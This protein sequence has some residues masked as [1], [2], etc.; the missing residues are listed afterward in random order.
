MLTSALV[1]MQ[2]LLSGASGA[3][4]MPSTGDPAPHPLG[5]TRQGDSLESGQFAGKV[6]VVSFW[7]SW[8]GPCM[9]ELPRLEAIQRVAGKDKLQVVA[10]NMEE[11]ERFR[12][13]SKAL[14]SYSLT[15]SF[16][17]RKQSSDA[18]GVHGIP[19]MVIIDRAGRIV[20]VHR[21]YSEEALDSILAEIN[22]ALRR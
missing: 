11:W 18:Y 7:A 12:R 1:A 15:V 20:R 14:E 6:L 2:L 13:I 10:I 21:G 17:D 19:H 8:C 9:K 22:D 5:V 4:G 16:D 3:A